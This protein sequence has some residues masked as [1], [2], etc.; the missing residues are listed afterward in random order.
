MTK[1]KG[2]HELTKMTEASCDIRVWSAACEHSE[3]STESDKYL[4]AAC[5]SIAG[6]DHEV[7]H[8]VFPHISGDH[9]NLS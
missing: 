7:H 8:E 1:N 4:C 2:T 5:G 3:Y 9:D 6:L